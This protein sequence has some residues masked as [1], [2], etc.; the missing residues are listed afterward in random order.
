MSKDPNYDIHASSND[1]N[2]Q[3]RMIA[4]AFGGVLAA[5]FAIGTYYFIQSVMAVM[6]VINQPFFDAGTFMMEYL[7]TSH[8]A[9]IVLLMAGLAGFG[10]IRGMR[11]GW[12]CAQVVAMFNILW[13]VEV[14][15]IGWEYLSFM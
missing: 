4:I 1:P 2:S 10:L 11:L 6:D 7:L 5:M 13:L 15:L 14:I 12:V 9:V 3:W 8:I